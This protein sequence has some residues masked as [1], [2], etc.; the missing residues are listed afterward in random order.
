M[1]RDSAVIFSPFCVFCEV[2]WTKI[3]IFTCNRGTFFINLLISSHPSHNFSRFLLLF[4][5]WCIATELGMGTMYLNLRRRCYGGIQNFHYIHTLMQSESGLIL[6]AGE[7]Q[8]PSMHIC[9]FRESG[10]QV[11]SVFFRCQESHCLDRTSA[12]LLPS[13]GGFLHV[14]S[15]YNQ[16]MAQESLAT[17]YDVRAVLWAKVL[18]KLLGFPGD[19]V[20]SAG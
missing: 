15:Y 5:H 16:E 12:F 18:W 20:K 2:D 9:M 13:C 4:F 3:Q 6:K 1:Q 11:L 19:Y 14:K 17:F 10:K 7:R 8:K